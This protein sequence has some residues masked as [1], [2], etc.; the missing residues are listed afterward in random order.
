MLVVV[1]VI[2][3]VFQKP[4]EHWLNRYFT[5]KEIS[6]EIISRSKLSRHEVQE[7][8]KTEGFGSFNLSLDDLIVEDYHLL[9]IRLKNEGI[10]IKGNLK[11]LVSIGNKYTKILDIK[12]KVNYPPNK[13]VSVFYALPKLT[14]SEKNKYKPSFS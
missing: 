2:A 12:H 3:F 13:K 10:P 4:I 1:A 8:S 14:W 7:Y 11:F 5:K 6:F 9:K